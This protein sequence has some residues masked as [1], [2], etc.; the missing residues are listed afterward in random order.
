[1]LARREDLK[2]DEGFTIS[3]NTDYAGT[4]DTGGGID[5]TGLYDYAY[6]P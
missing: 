4:T 2:N 6:R 1:M 5:E 3:L